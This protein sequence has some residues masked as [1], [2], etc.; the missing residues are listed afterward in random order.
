MQYVVAVAS[1][2]RL[3]F[4]MALNTLIYP[5]PKV[6]IQY[7]PPCHN[8]PAAEVLQLQSTVSL[9]FW[10]RLQT[11]RAHGDGIFSALWSAGLQLAWCRTTPFHWAAELWASTANFAVAARGGYISLKQPILLFLGF[12]FRIIDCRSTRKPVLTLT[13]KIEGS[14]GL[15]YGNF[16]PLPGKL[17]GDFSFLVTGRPG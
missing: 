3:L 4:A 17:L 7:R 15:M 9:L 1:S 13:Y 16:P 10:Q 5:F 12:I 8:Q 14:S 2:T 11:F 6:N